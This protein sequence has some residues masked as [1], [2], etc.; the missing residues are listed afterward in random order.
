MNAP[1]LSEKPDTA[2]APRDASDQEGVSCANC[3]RLRAQLQVALA[4]LEVLEKRV[5]Q[6]EGEVR[7]GKRQA[8]PFA[9]DRKEKKARKRPG[10]R[11]GEGTF[12]RREPPPDSEVEETRVVEMQCCPDCGGEDL[13]AQA[14]RE[15]F[16]VD[17]P[18]VKPVWRRYL[19]HSAYCGTC[20]KRVVA[21]HPEQ[22]SVATGAAGVVV[23]ART[24][25]LAADLKHR[26]GVPLRK[27]TELFRTAFGLEITPGA[28]SQASARLA[29]TARP[30]QGEIAVRLGEAAAVHA[31][32]TGWRIGGVP[33]HLWVFASAEATLYAIDERRSHEVP[34]EVLG[35]HFG[36]VLV[37]DCAP[38][39]DHHRLGS[40]R[41]QKCWAHLRKDLQAILEEATDR[42]ALRFA[43]AVTRAYD[44]ARVLAS[45]RE[46][47]KQRCVAERRTEIEDELDRWLK[48]SPGHDERARRMQKRL[49]KQRD[50][51]FTFL[52]DPR[53]EA[54]NNR[55]ERM[56]RPGVI[57]RK[58]GGCNR[59]RHGAWTHEI[60][61][62]VLVTLRQQGRDTLGFLQSVMC[63]PN[64]LPNLFPTPAVH[65]AR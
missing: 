59:S 51:L 22:V 57:T 3:E 6:L 13:E 58:T 36:G 26:L 45:A 49:K 33:A 10:R 8:A 54:T 28:L 62:S 23:G 55:A 12:S 34:L 5:K 53:A 60:L 14:V 16:E 21:R 27:I 30:L 25:A 65:P 11:P 29:R 9:R 37:S 43:R 32:D 42:Q 52:E 64:A 31:D 39:F 1:A 15:Q 48:C 63:A 41:Q 20:R 40:W 61:A 56:L 7:R 38:A 17:L 50:H 2:P 18:P 47:M 44:A 46:R 19:F 35:E 24:Q 4:R